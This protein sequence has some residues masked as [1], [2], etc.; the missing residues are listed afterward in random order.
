MSAHRVIQS[1]VELTGPFF[2]RDVRKTVRQNISD[3][4]D[5]IAEYGQERAR[6]QIEA[7]QGAMPGY[8]GWTHDRT[9]G[10]TRAEARR[11][12]K[13]WQVTAVISANTDGMGRR[14]AIRTKAAAS[15][16]ERRFHVFRSTTFAIRARMKTV[17]LTKGLE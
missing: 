11:G 13:K 1:E 6:A 14:D 16:I 7:R 2:T 9:I 15:G 10:R 17:N 5:A 4:E 12:G 8:T 3:F